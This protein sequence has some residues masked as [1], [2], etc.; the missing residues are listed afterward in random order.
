[1]LARGEGSFQAHHRGGLR[2]H[3]LGNLRLG[4]SGLVARFKQGIQKHGFF[5]LNSIHFGLDAGTFNQLFDELVM[6]FQV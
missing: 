4:E 2:S 1:M 5:A 6:C 3:A